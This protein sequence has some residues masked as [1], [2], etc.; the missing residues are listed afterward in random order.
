MRILADENVPAEYAAALRGDGHEVRYSR[1][2]EALG[3]EAS[4]EDITTYAERETWALLSTDEKD[5][6]RRDASVPV[7]VAPQDMS[8]G[9]VQAAIA[10]IQALPLDPSQTDPLWLSTV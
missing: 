1:D 9:D 6:G 3:P 8:A 7:F 4:D 10:R 2:I 5:F